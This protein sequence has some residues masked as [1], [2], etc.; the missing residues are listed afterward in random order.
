MPGEGVPIHHVLGGGS[1]L[2]RVGRELSMALERQL[3]PFDV[4]P[5]QAA[6]LL[7]S[8]PR[9]TSPS[10]LLEIL[11]TD[12]A[13]M[14]RLLDRLEGKGLI[15]R[16]KHADD[17]RSII[18]ELTQQGLALIPRLAPVFGRVTGQLMAGFSEQ[19]VLQVTTMLQR[20]L[21]NLQSARK[22]PR[23]GQDSGAQA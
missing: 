9:E 1:L 3:A 22:T 2:H 19:E 21:D 17:R 4:T 6:L 8:A 20:M 12:T 5:Q 15:V 11:G 14:T 16:R 7:Q 10:Q 23:A 18:I 13:G